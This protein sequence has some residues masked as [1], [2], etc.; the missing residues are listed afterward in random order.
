MDGLSVKDK[1]NINYAKCVL[2]MI[3]NNANAIDTIR[4]NKEYGYVLHLIAHRDVFRALE[5][6]T[7]YHGAFSNEHDIDKIGLSIALGK[8][9][10]REIHKKIAKH[11]NINWENPDRTILVEKLFDW[12]SCHYTKLGV[13]ETAYEYSMRK[14][15][16]VINIIEPM[17]KELGFWESKNENI[18]T[19][20]RY[21]KIVESI[22]EEHILSEVRKSYAY[23]EK[24]F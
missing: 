9:R 15:L 22:P 20:E 23:L 2:R 5:L 4:E 17:L 1:N 13:Y 18:L 8:D 14:H 21:S 16:D 10:A 24:N 6:H 12:E 3:L 7:A 19:P 11:H